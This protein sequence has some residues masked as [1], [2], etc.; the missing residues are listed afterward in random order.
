MNPGNHYAQSSISIRGLLPKVV[1]SIHYD[2][3]GEVANIQQL[4]EKLRQE[5]HRASVLNLPGKPTILILTPHACVF[6]TGEAAVAARVSIFSFPSYGSPDSAET[7]G[8]TPK[9]FLAYR[10]G[11]SWSRSYSESQRIF[12]GSVSSVTG[13]GDASCS[14]SSDSTSASR[15][16]LSGCFLHSSLGGM[17]FFGG[18]GIFNLSRDGNNNE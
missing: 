10:I 3:L 4:R 9:L 12:V 5:L 11:R 17:A 8:W 16:S 7:P 2:W 13:S 18:F 6:E 14:A 1:S 15:G